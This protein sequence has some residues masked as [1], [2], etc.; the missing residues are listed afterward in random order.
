MLDAGLE[1]GR[2][3]RHVAAAGSAEP[4]D[5]IKAE[6][7]DRR[8]GR[9]LPGMIEINALPQC[10]ALAGPVE[11]DDGNAEIG[12]WQK[13][14]VELLNERVVSAGEDERAALLAFGLQPETGQMSARIRNCDAL[15]AGDTSHAERPIPRKVVV[16]SVAHIAGRQIELGAVI[17]GGG[18]EM[19]LLALRLLGNLKPHRVP[20][21]VVLDTRRDGGEFLEARW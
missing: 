3:D 8:L 15:V 9:L 13:E 7:I 18:V 14:V 10:A 17:I 16:K 19:S 2:A 12:Q 4:I 20:G 11:G 1:R 6:V 21:I 5:C